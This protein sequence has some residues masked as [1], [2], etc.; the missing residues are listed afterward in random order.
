MFAKIQCLRQA[1]IDICVTSSTIESPVSAIK[2]VVPPPTVIKHHH[3]DSGLCSPMT[4]EVSILHLTS[5]VL[6]AVCFSIQR[7]IVHTR[8][9]TPLR[10]LQRVDLS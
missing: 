6:Y 3:P 4:A 2:A 5:L 1:G 10:G 9:H 7:S 8:E